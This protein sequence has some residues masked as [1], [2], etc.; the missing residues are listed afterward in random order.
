MNHHLLIKYFLHL[1][2]FSLDLFI[3]LIGFLNLLLLFSSFLQ[4]NLLVVELSLFLMLMLCDSFVVFIDP[5]VVLIAMLPFFVSVV[6]YRILVVKVVHLLHPLHRSLFVFL[7]LLFFNLTIQLV[8]HFFPIFVHL[9]VSGHLGLVSNIHAVVRSV[10]LILL[11][12]F[13]INNIGE[14]MP[15]LRL[16]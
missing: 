1:L 10:T 3:F 13:G 16:Y 4:L 5:W 9:P 8:H 12:N 14:K 7:S 6:K 2:I 15:I 11:F